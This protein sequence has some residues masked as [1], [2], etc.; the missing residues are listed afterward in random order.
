[1]VTGLLEVGFVSSYVRLP[2]GIF[3][4]MRVRRCIHFHV[5]ASLLIFPVIG[6]IYIFIF[7]FAVSSVQFSPVFA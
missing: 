1:M 2:L 7:A 4:L 5:H 6:S 3:I